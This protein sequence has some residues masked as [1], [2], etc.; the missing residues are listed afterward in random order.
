MFADNAKTDLTCH[1]EQCTTNVGSCF[2]IVLTLQNM[3]F[4]S[5]NLQ[6]FIFIFVFTHQS[7][8]DSLVHI[9]LTFYE[10]VHWLNNLFPLFDDI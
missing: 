3:R 5:L 4:L 10:M 8:T 1:A 6:F 2:A 9:I 7:T